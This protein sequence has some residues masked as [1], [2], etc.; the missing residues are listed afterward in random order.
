MNRSIASYG[1]NLPPIDEIRLLRLANKPAQP[2]LGT[3]KIPFHEGPDLRIVADKTLAGTAAQS[4]ANQ[5]RQL[6]LH[7]DY[8]AGCYDPHHVLQFR[9]GG[10]VI[11]EAVMCFACGNTTLPAFPI[12]TLVSFENADGGSPSYRQFK[13]SVEAE[14]GAHVETK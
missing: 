5:W 14:I 2:D 6:R 3:F 1:S 12:R 10:K 11:C 4:L 8:M 13:Q 9:S 7:N